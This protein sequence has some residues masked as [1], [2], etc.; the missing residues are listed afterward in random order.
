MLSQEPLMLLRQGS[1]K[2]MHLRESHTISKS[3]ELSLKICDLCISDLQVR[4]SKTLINGAYT[5]NYQDIYLSR[6]LTNTGR[7]NLHFMIKITVVLMT[8][9][10][11]Y[12]LKL[13]VNSIYSTF[14][15]WIILDQNV[16]VTRVYLMKAQSEVFKSKNP[17]GYFSQELLTT[18]FNRIRKQIRKQ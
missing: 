6:I 15:S 3:R 1:N 7:K 12:A 4:K 16:T 13:E 10:N 5:G 14:S 11:L 9:F 8:S 17:R 18:T 2:L